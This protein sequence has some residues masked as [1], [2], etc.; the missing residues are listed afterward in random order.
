MLHIPE[1]IHIIILYLSSDKSDGHL[2]FENRR[3]CNLKDP[4]INVDVAN[5]KYVDEK[6]NAI[7]NELVKKIEATD[8]LYMQATF[9]MQGDRKA[10]QI[11]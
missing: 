1:V 6:Y 10:T 3:L 11:A 4:C 9:N 5:K 7:F 8:N 2:F